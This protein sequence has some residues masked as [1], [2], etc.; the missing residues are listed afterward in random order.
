M[1]HS[2]RFK[3]AEMANFLKVPCSLFE[4]ILCLGVE[5]VVFSPSEKLEPIQWEQ[6]SENE[7]VHDTDLPPIHHLADIAIDDSLQPITPL[8]AD[9]EEPED[10][11]NS[12]FQIKT[13]MKLKSFLNKVAE[14]V[15]T[16]SQKKASTIETQSVALEEEVCS[17]VE[18]MGVTSPVGWDKNVPGDVVRSVWV[19]GPGNR[20][21]LIVVS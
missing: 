11:S 21:Q 4:I 2:T 16:L 13:K 14:N 15:E 3:A 1:H 18:Y 10:P 6:P 5:R 7:I 20:Q 8:N 9:F 17:Y 19:V 12:D